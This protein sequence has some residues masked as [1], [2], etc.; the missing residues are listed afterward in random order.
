MS[1]LAYNFSILDMHYSLIILVF[2]HHIVQM[3]L[4]YLKLVILFS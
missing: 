4:M 3:L 2:E 1:Q